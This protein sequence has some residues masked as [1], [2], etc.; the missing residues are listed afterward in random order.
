HFH[1]RDYSG[2]VGNVNL[3]WGITSKTRITASWSRDLANYQTAVS[4]FLSPNLARFSSSF[5]ATNRFSVMPVWKI[6]DKTTLRLRY[7]Y[8]MADFGGA[9][10]LFP[11]GERSDSMHSGMIALD[12]QPLNMIA[13]S[14]MLQRDH[15]TSSHRGFDFDSSA[16][17]ISAKLTF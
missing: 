9:V 16:A 2:F 17:S 12:W 8:T 5:V 14:G 1:Q 4:F 11:Q 7:D 3:N 13:I 15:R 6:T 10:Q